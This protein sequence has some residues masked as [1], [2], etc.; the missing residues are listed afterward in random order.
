MPVSETLN[1]QE[2]EG[3]LCK[4]C[5]TNSDTLEK[6]RGLP[7]QFKI[8]ANMRFATFDC[9]VMRSDKV[10][11]VEERLEAFKNRLCDPSSM[12]VV[13]TAKF[14]IIKFKSKLNA[15]RFLIQMSENRPLLDRNCIFKVHADD[16]IAVTAGCDNVKPVYLPGNENLVMKHSLPENK[17]PQEDFDS[18]KAAEVVIG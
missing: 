7:I 15:F 10:S 18:T 3:F 13:N 6:V 2:L 1:S 16:D 14:I 11:D 12:N 8:A 17:L 9:Y 4:Y 5:S